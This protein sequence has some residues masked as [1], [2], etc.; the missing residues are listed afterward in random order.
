[1]G[2][3]E[4]DKVSGRQDVLSPNSHYIFTNLF[5]VFTV[6]STAIW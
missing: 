3:G 5:T 6:I 1:M 2:C 4:S